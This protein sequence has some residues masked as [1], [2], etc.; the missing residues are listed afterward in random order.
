[1]K[2]VVVFT[3]EAGWDPV[4]VEMRT[5]GNTDPYEA[6]EKACQ[7]ASADDVRVMNY[8][9]PGKY[10][11]EVGLT[12]VPFE[13][14]SVASRDLRPENPVFSLCCC[15]N[16]SAY[17]EGHCFKYGGLVDG[18]ANAVDCDCIHGTCGKKLLYD[19]M[20]VIEYP[21]ETTMT[22]QETARFLINTDD[23]ELEVLKVDIKDFLENI[24]DENGFINETKWS[25]GEDC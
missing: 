1:M 8:Q 23:E 4:V 6:F 18:F 20:E 22:P 19:G 25:F 10:A 11:K 24:L 12:I 13:T 16:C 21:F 15:S 5:R 3:N 7:K 9:I 14:I 17:E 2:K